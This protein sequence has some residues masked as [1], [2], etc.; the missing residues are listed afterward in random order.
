MAAAI[1]IS[2]AHED[3]ERAELIA[4]S[5][6]ANGWSVWWDRQIRGGRQ[7]DKATEEAIAAAR[8]V[9]VLWS[10]SSIT[11]DWVR[12]EAAWALA[13]DKLLPVT[14]DDV[15]PPLRFLHVQ[16]VDLV[17]PEDPTRAP[18]FDLVLSE[19]AQQVLH[20]GDGVKLAA[21]IDVPRSP[22]RP[23]RS[24]L[25]PPGRVAAPQ[26]PSPAREKPRLTSNPADGGVRKSRSPWQLPMA[27]L[28]IAVFCLLVGFTY[29]MLSDE[30]PSRPAIS[31]KE[32]KQATPPKENTANVVSKL[33]SNMLPTL[34]PPPR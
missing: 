11:S 30:N 1:F 3:R 27:A 10:Q 16:T 14:I 12:A 18:G 8:V 20:K 2:Y 26:P 24:E 5:L 31:R 33:P 13:K 19:I 7:F 32:Q 25:R 6:T 21:I 9:V 4:S 17:G 15:Q 22:V 29:L 28:G 23:S 34:M